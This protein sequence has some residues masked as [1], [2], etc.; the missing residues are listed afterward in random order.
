MEKYTNLRTN[1]K[2]HKW[3]DDNRGF[4]PKSKFLELVIEKIEISFNA[5][6]EL[7]IKVKEE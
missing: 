1:E 4:I 7:I 3:L 6:G 2:V 5:T